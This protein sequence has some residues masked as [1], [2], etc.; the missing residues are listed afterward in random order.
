MW[1]RA[2]R[3]IFAAGGWV[4]DGW[5]VSGDVVGGEIGALVGELGGRVSGIGYIRILQGIMVGWA[6]AP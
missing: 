3:Q 2:G 6:M 4:D 5:M 1:G